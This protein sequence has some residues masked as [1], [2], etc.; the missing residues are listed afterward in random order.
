[1]TLQAPTH[2]L[3]GRFL[4]RLA[5][6]LASPAVYE[7]VLVPLLADFQFEYRRA[8]SSSA[9]LRVRLT[10]TLAFGRTL[11]LEAVNALALHLRTNSWG[12]TDEERSVARRQRTRCPRVVAALGLGTLGWRGPRRPPAA[13][14]GYSVQNG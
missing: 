4:L 10:W 5:H 9:R 14:A 7:R 11:G 6:R 1:M 12:T 2:D 13:A 3:P 8:P